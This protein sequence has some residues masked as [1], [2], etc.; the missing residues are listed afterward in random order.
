M[1]GVAA[2][3]RA[4]H[5]TPGRRV[6]SKRVGRQLHKDSLQGGF[7]LV[8]MVHCRLLDPGNV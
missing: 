3:W 4:T 5:L 7:R 8:E 2:T 1:A 6:T